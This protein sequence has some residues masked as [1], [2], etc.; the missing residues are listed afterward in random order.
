MHSLIDR[1]CRLILM[2]G[3]CL[4]SGCGRITSLPRAARRARIVLL[5]AGGCPAWR[6]AE[7]VRVDVSTV[8][9]WRDRY[10]REELAGLENRPCSGRPAGVRAGGAAADRGGGHRRTP[11]PPP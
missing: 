7:I 11:S 5:A 8:V 4:G 9:R 3:V 6:I 1:V 2:I 10:A